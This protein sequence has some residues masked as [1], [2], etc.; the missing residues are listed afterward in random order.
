M[1]L[2]FHLPLN[3]TARAKLLA[4][5]LLLVVPALGMYGGYYLEKEGLAPTVLGRQRPEVTIP[6]L[7]GPPV[8]NQ[9]GPS[10]IDVDN[11]M[12]ADPPPDT[13][14]HQSPSKLI[15]AIPSL[16]S[17]ED[18]AKRWQPLA[19]HLSK[20]AKL[21]VSIEVAAPDQKHGLI[22]MRRGDVHLALVGAGAVPLAVNAA[23]FVPVA[24]L[25]TGTGEGFSKMVFVVPAS[26]PIQTPFEL[27][28]AELLFVEPTSNTG[29]KAA[30]VALRDD[31]GLRPERDFTW[32]FSGSPVESIDAIKQK[33]AVAAALAANNVTEALEAGRISADDIRVIY[34][35]EKFPTA[36]IGYAHNLDVA[37]AGKLRRAILSF[38]WKQ[39][40]LEDVLGSKFTR[41]VP[42][43]YRNDW[44]MVR[45][46]DDVTGT[47]HHLG[48][49]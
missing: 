14:E 35:S 21:P 28:G 48:P 9:L 13:R 15:L 26:S 49:K 12:I 32:N 41:F 47:L 22:A 17:H 2:S 40:P 37:L 4:A 3:R 42:T 24:M 11:D 16:S 27:R 39:T 18:Y 7:I 45:R 34:Q 6:R 29:F 36:A 20:S 31:F 19:D 5:V 38:D 23:G 33:R 43:N 10:F 44:S 25:P 1:K 46:I 30:I 8:H